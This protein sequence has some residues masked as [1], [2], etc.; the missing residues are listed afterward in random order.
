MVPPLPPRLKLAHNMPPTMEGKR[1][2][3][4]LLAHSMSLL[5]E[6]PR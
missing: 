6:T 1:S 3:H 2:G 5:E 4:M